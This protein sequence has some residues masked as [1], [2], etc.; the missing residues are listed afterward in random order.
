M[1]DHTLSMDEVRA[2]FPFSDDREKF[3]L[4]LAAHDRKIAAEALRALGQ[5]FHDWA[6][7]YA[8]PDG[9]HFALVWEKRIR[10]RADRIEQGGES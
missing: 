10:E 8:G 7:L 6:A 9:A 1:I 3:D 4:A 5:E 2:W